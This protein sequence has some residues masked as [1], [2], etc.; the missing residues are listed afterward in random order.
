MMKR[1]GST[2]KTSWLEGRIYLELKVVR[3]R[4]RY[5]RPSNQLVLLVLKKM[6][7]NVFKNVK[8]KIQ[9]MHQLTEADIKLLL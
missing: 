9:S 6:L 7:K 4:T 2:S 8:I 5:I 1:E 3:M